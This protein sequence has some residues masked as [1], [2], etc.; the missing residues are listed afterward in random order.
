MKE[1][2]FQQYPVQLT[3]KVLIYND[4]YIFSFYKKF[5]ENRR[6]IEIKNKLTNSFCFCSIKK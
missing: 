3:L 1:T 4:F 6:F 2:Q 5:K